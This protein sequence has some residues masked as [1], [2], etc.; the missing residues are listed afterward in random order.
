MNRMTTWGRVAALSVLACASLGAQAALFSDDEA[1]KAILELRQRQDAH[2][3]ATDA[4]TVRLDDENAQLRRS[5][6]N[7]QG[8]ID[9]LRTELSGLRGQNEQLA[10]ELAESQRRQKDLAQNVEERLRR[11]EPVTVSLDGREFLADP[12][13]KRDFD[14]AIAVFKTGNFAAAQN[15]LL[16]FARRYPASG[17]RPAAL[18]W[19]GNAQYGTRDY[20][21]AITNFRLMLTEAPDH[22]RAPEAMLS[23][24]N[25]QLE[26]KDA[27]AARRTLE[28]LAK[29]HP[30]SEAA[31]AARERLARLR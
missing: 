9:A 21:E 5:L 14:A 19:L 20:N 29:A 18:F 13:E 8:Q 6:L 11:F 26:L 15:S 25:C 12:A 31:Q 2:K 28:D 7:L 24:A 23:I 4:A 22:P 3:Q 10:R 17:Y 27:K 1:R 30:Q 16:G